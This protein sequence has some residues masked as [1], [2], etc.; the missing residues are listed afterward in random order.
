MNNLNFFILLS[1]LIYFKLTENKSGNLKI[2]VGLVSL[3]TLYNILTGPEGLYSAAPSDSSTDPTF[4][5]GAS[6]WV[7][8]SPSSPPYDF[9]PHCK[10]NSANKI[11][12]RYKDSTGTLINAPSPGYALKTDTNCNAIDCEPHRGNEHC[13]EDHICDD[14]EC[15]AC[16]VDSNC[17]TNE[18]CVNNICVSNTKECPS[19]CN[20]LQDPS[21]GEPGCGTMDN[22]GTC[23]DPSDCCTTKPELM[24]ILYI[25]LAI[26]GFAVAVGL[27]KLNKRRGKRKSTSGEGT[28]SGETH[29]IEVNISER[30]GSTTS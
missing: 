9:P 24:Y 27:W 19:S 3:Y 21:P 11:C 4:C 26:V 20:F 25:F 30:G 6:T 15:V 8:G 1:T 13:N 12:G 2:V 10:R 7:A 14:G 18:K 23:A 28:G 16:T 22:S 29:G 5:K 17:E